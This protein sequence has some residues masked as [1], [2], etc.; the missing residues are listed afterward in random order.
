MTK[1]DSLLN[2]TSKD[3]CLQFMYWCLEFFVIFISINNNCPRISS[4]NLCD[5]ITKILWNFHA[6]NLRM[7]DLIVWLT[8]KNVTISFDN[9]PECYGFVSEHYKNLS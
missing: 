1:K 3:S 6:S 2:L 7:L 8:H 5:A 9:I 4:T